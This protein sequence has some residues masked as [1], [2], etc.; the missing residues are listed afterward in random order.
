[1][2]CYAYVW[3]VTVMCVVEVNVTFPYVIRFVVTLYIPTLGAK[4]VQ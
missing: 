1:M 3:R 2:I 4:L